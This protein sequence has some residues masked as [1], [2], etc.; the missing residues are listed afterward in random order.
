M[1][2]VVADVPAKKEDEEIGAEKEEN[3][4]VE[5]QNDATTTMET[6]PT[7]QTNNSD[8]AATAATEQPAAAPETLSQQTIQ[9]Y[10]D[11][12]INLKPDV[13][14]FVLPVEDFGQFDVNAVFPDLL[15]YEP[16][17]PD[18]NDPYFDEVEYGRIIA[19]TNLS[20]NK[21]VLK[22]KPRLSKKRNFDGE[23]V[24][25]YEKDDEENDV[26]VLP[27]KERYDTNPLLSR[28]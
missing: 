9:T 19:I 10:R 15:S 21:I 26:Q 25:I 11:K 7:N 18:Y 4:A 13:P 6:A 1:Q 20:T 5:E 23:Q 24:P 3:V 14:T 2:D 27:D 22:K 28:K 12:I 16:P 8:T 17:K